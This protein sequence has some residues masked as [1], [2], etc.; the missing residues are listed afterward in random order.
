MIAVDLRDRPAKQIHS[1][2]R[3][4]LGLGCGCYG[5]SGVPGVSAGGGEGTRTSSHGI[6]GSPQHRSLI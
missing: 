5:L 2:G 3:W 6:Q 4:E 1:D